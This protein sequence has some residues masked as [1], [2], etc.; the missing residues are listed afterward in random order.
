M[1]ALFLLFLSSCTFL[2][3]YPDNPLEEI[4]ED[5]IEEQTGVEVDFTGSSPET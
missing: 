2:N 4:V 5:V 1:K 3:R